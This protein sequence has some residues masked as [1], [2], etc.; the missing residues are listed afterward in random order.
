MRST[1]KRVLW[2]ILPTPLYHRYKRL[3]VSL[4]PWRRRPRVVPF[5]K[6]Y[7]APLRCYI[8]YNI[9]GRYCVP[10]SSSQ[11]PAAQAILAGNVWEPDTIDLM[12]SYCPAGDV[13]HAGTYFGDFLPA[14][15][16]RLGEGGVVWAFEP[17]PEN[18]RCADITVRINELRNVS[19]FNA[20]LGE[21]SGRLQMAVFDK[22]GRALGGYSH[23]ATEADEGRSVISV[24]I[25]S[26]DDVIPPDRTV[27][28]I[29]LDVEGFECPALRGAIATIE[30]CRPLI[31][32][33]NLPT[34]SAL[35]QTLQC[36]GYKVTGRCH[37]NFVLSPTGK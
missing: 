31:V 10:L 12:M 26:V 11:R 17:N 14:L 25:V 22:K 13:V 20:G 36:I 2:R 9:Y 34:D 5:D 19:L 29:Q 18:H 1:I 33:E 30:R 23:V 32:V 21:R 37:D 15:S 4:R 24:E 16:R 7:P 6:H 28:V 3:S 27:A 8:A 35:M